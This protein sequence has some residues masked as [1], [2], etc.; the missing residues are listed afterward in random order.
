MKK[1]SPQKPRKCQM[2]EIVIVSLQILSE[3]LLIIIEE[4]I[5]VISKYKSILRCMCIKK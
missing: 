5:F 1:K 2:I 3:F 4:Q